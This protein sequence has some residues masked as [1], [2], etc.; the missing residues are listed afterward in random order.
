MQ[1]KLW[2][3]KKFLEYINW[4]NPEFRQK[5]GLGFGSFSLYLVGSYRTKLCLD[6]RQNSEIQKWAKN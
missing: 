3:F 5:M 6:F 1:F 2:Y 4:L